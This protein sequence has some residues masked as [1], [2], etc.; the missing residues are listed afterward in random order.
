MGM[1]IHCGGTPASYED[2]KAVVTPAATD[3]FCPVPHH[4]M[5]DLMKTEAKAILP[6]SMPL[7]QEA[8][9]LNRNGQQFF[10]WLAFAGDDDQSRMQVGM[11]GA[12]DHSMRRE[13]RSGKNVTVC[14]NMMMSGGG[15]HVVH[16]HTRNIWTN[17]VEKVREALR[18]AP[19]EYARLLLDTQAMQERSCSEDRGAELIG[20]AMYHGLLSPRQAKLTIADWQ[21][22]GTEEVRHEEHDQR[23]AWGLYNCFTEGLKLG[24]VN[25]VMERHAGAHDFFRQQFWLPEPA[26]VVSQA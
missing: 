16:K 14:D 5:I 4:A 8:Y 22:V 17:L 12:H 13:F 6:A 7:V 21:N 23:T 19:Q 3:T 2:V 15:M 18:L 1:I 11:R 9:G 26:K 20:K 24:G 25:D 10:G